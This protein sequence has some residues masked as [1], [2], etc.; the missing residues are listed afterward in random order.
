MAAG[1]CSILRSGGDAKVG[2]AIIEAIPV[3]MIHHKTR[4]D[5]QNQV[6]K[7]D[8]A[9]AQSL[10]H[11]G[12]RIPNTALPTGIPAE[13]FQQVSVL[14]IDPENHSIGEFA[15]NH[16]PAATSTRLHFHQ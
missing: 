1:V 10:P 7:P 9:L 8:D 4:R 14:F 5:G 15:T 11:I 2:P 13:G 16:E 3:E 6:V 12:K